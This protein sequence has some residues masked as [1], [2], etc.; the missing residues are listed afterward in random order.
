MKNGRK[1]AEMLGSAAVGYGLGIFNPAYVIGKKNGYDIR[2]MGSKNAG[3]SNT[4]IVEGKKSAAVVMAA[5]IGKAALAVELSKKLFPDCEYAEETAGTAAILGH[6]FPVTM[7]FRGG[8][9]LACLGGTI[10][11][12]GLK[13]FAVMLGLELGVLVCTKYICLVPITASLFYPVYHGIMKR[14][15]RGGAILGAV[16]PPIILKHRENLRRIAE[17]KEFRINFLWDREGELQRT[18]WLEEMN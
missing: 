18:G 14:D 7:S 15:W 6:M 2:E 3:A 11:A 1:A 16:V 17:G 13:D 10:M 12:L 8:K 9:G 5:D 4:L